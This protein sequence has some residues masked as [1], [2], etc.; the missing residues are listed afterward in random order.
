MEEEQFIDFTQKGSKGSNGMIKYSREELLAIGRKPGL[1]APPVGVNMSVLRELEELTFFDSGP[2]PEWAKEKPAYGRLDFL[3]PGGG[4]GGPIRS[5]LVGDGSLPEE[6]PPARSV[7]LLGPP[8]GSSEGMDIRR[9]SSWRPPPE[10]SG[11]TPPGDRWSGPTTPGRRLGPEEP[12]RRGGRWDETKASTPERDSWR[13]NSLSSPPTDDRGGWRGGGAAA[14]SSSS[15]LAAR[16]PPAPPGRW[17][18]EEDRP[19]GA[20]WGGSSGAGPS[21][22]SMDVDR[23]VPRRPPPGMG[24]DEKWSRGGWGEGGHEREREGGAPGWGRREGGPPGGGGYGGGGGAHWERDPA[25]MHDGQQATAEG[26]SRSTMPT[27]PAGGRAGMTAKDIER[28][29]QEMQAQWRAEAAAKKGQEEDDMAFLRSDSDDE[30]QQQ[31]P[32]A[33]SRQGSLHLDQQASLPGGSHPSRSRF[34]DVP[35]ADGQP[36]PPPPPRQQSGPQ[37]GTPSGGSDGPSV[38]GRKLTFDQ[39]KAAAA[40]GNVSSPAAPHPP[41][42][43][44][45]Q[46]Q[47]QQQGQVPGKALTM[48]ELEHQ[49]SGGPPAPPAAQP[50][51]P[52]GMPGS[53][54]DTEASKKLMAFLKKPA[55]AAPGQQQQQHAAPQAPPPG[56]GFGPPPPQPVAAAAAAGLRPLAATVSDAASAADHADEDLAKLAGLLDLGLDEDATASGLAGKLA[57]LAKRESDAAGGAAKRDSASGLSPT[58]GTGFDSVLGG[59]K[60]PSALAGI[61]GSGLGV[62]DHGPKSAGAT[63]ASSLLPG[64]SPFG[65]GLAGFGAPSASAPQQPAAAQPQQPAA[66]LGDGLR[67]PA[68]VLPAQRPGM[69]QPGVFGMSAQ[70]QQAQL[71]QLLSQAQQRV[72]GMPGMS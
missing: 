69:G 48:A 30:Q 72:P 37:P 2:K 16:A 70:D 67:P 23:E 53:K 5:R 58:L 42:E 47:Q 45:Q 39:F 9:S 62:W 26:P 13:S 25:W 12:P 61:W 43:Q 56:M 36:P 24:H 44:Q 7:D 50:P 6:L 32:R 27:A 21:R 31:Q 19:R 55:A 71:R 8:R 10:S 52:P 20:G 60:V 51:P 49:M 35:S 14:G 46:Q 1:T 68:L 22:G 15:G 63:S 17:G 40:G 41:P 38:L 59:G 18:G 66:S 54:V 57:T 4:F 28:E 65:G 29:R 33:S 64:A 3:R 11:L 34:F